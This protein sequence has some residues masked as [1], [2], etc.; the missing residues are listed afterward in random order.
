MP[1]VAVV[2]CIRR[3]TDPEE[4]VGHL[5]RIACPGGSVR[6]DTDSHALGGRLGA[7]G[8]PLVEA[9]FAR[10]LGGLSSAPHEREAQAGH[11]RESLG[12]AKKM[13]GPECCLH[14][15]I[16]VARSMQPANLD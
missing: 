11:E 2:T 7:H 8:D 6:Q 10:I 9:T 3:K 14:A 1:S 4:N 13:G 16:I 15:K 5:S 12:H